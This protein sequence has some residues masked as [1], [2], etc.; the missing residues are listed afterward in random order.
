MSVTQSTKAL[1]SSLSESQFSESA[2][3]IEVKSLSFERYFK[4]QDG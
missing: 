3:M 2:E 1:I 4:E